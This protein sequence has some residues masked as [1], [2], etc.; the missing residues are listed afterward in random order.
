MADEEF[1]SFPSRLDDAPKARRPSVW[2]TISNPNVRWYAHAWLW[3]LVAFG[4]FLST[5]AK[6]GWSEYTAPSISVHIC[7]MPDG[8]AVVGRGIP[9]AIEEWACDVQIMH[10]W[11][12][13]YQRLVARAGFRDGFRYG[14]ME[15][16]SG[17]ASLN[18]PSPEDIQHLRAAL[19]SFL[20]TQPNAGVVTYDQP[21]IAY[22][23]AALIR[24][25][26]TEM[27]QTSPLRALLWIVSIAAILVMVGA[28]VVGATRI[29]RLLQCRVQLRRLNSGKCPSCAYPVLGIE[30][31]R[32]CPECGCDTAAIAIEA[33]RYNF[34]D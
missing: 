7:I 4:I 8:E 11:A 32:R 23:L 10:T 15:H 9:T 34:I 17:G 25:D 26:R 22:N 24:E 21:L 28:I 2:N 31:F 20:E 3:A 14:S 19:A 5:Y 12:W 1:A 30:D 27:R 29:A 16:S 13:R 18:K 33:R 6:V